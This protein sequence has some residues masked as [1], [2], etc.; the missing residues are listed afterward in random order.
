MTLGSSMK[1][2]VATEE[3][4]LQALEKQVSETKAVLQSTAQETAWSAA[5]HPAFVQ[6][7]ASQFF[8]QTVKSW[9]QF[10]IDSWHRSQGSPDWTAWRNRLLQVETS[11]S[12]AEGVQDVKHD[13]LTNDLA[14]IKIGLQE[15]MEE[16]KDKIERLEKDNANLRAVVKANADKFAKDVQN[17]HKMYDGYYHRTKTNVDELKNSLPKTVC[18]R[19]KREL[20]ESITGLS[21]T[22]E[23]GSSS[24]E[25]PSKLSRH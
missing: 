6:Q 3:A 12:H 16:T 1:S 24:D 21:N 8:E 9:V 19:A 17:M 20:L 15:F 10:M 23:R 13:T 2:D 18:D 7:V 14:Q 11:I 5:W 4:R 22:F 25:R